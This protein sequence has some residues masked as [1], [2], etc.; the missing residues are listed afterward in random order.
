MKHRAM[1]YF[2][3]L[4]RSDFS[5]TLI[6]IPLFALSMVYA[7]IAYTGE[8]K[9][10]NMGVYFLVA[11][12]KGFLLVFFIFCLEYKLRFRRKFSAMSS[13]G[14]KPYFFDVT[15]KDEAFRLFFANFLSL[16]YVAD[17]ILNWPS[18]MSEAFLFGSF[19]GSVLFGIIYL[20]DT[21]KFTSCIPWG[22]MRRACFIDDFAGTDLAITYLTD[23]NMI[24]DDICP[25]KI[26]VSADSLSMV[27]YL[28]NKGADPLLVV[29]GETILDYAKNN[30]SGE[31][32]RYM[33]ERVIAKQ[34][35]RFLDG[36]IEI[37]SE[38]EVLSF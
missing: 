22:I 20:S 28:M 23:T 26:A 35:N 21:Y 30:S 16:V 4:R 13:L 1:Q 33:Q 10:I 38:S 27:E 36:L 2:D 7:C 24:K 14:I 32:Y 15:M 9:L 5:L 6:A 17:I 8:Y 31:V 3:E 12:N 37:E 18:D 25:L 29:D 34:D 19:V 11:F